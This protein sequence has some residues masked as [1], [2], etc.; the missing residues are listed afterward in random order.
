MFSL[1]F[2][3]T[4]LD[5]INITIVSSKQILIYDIYNSK[6]IKTFRVVSDLFLAILSLNVFIRISKNELNHLQ[7]LEL[8][9]I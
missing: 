5:F 7:I 6:N 3:F 2:L 4:F 9:L 1:Y 8:I